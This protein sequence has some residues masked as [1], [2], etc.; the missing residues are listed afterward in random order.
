MSSVRDELRKR[1]EIYCEQRES[2]LTENSSFGFGV[3]GSVFECQRATAS[4]K[5]ALKIHERRTPYF[6]ERD[7]YL[8]LQDLGMD[9]VEGH[10]IPVLIDIDDELWAIEMSIVT[11][12][13]VLDFGGAYLDNPPD[14]GEAV[15]EQWERDKQEQF[16]ANWPHAASILETLKSYGIYVADVNPGNIGFVT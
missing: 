5:T 9:E 10:H 2:I 6:R 8:R 12:P 3:H 4:F 16:E 14:Y 1:A 7:V 11:R 13:F 15:M